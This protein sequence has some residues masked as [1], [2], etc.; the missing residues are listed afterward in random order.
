MAKLAAAWPR[1]L[2]VAELV[3]DDERRMALLR[4]YWADLLE[5]APAPSAFQVEVSERPAASP[6]A[7][8]Q[9]SRG[10]T[11]LITL[12]GT[13]VTLDDPV[14]RFFVSL[15][16]GSRTHDEIAEAMAGQVG[17]PL[18]AVRAALPDQLKALAR[19]PLLIS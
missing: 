10:E 2:P 8:L 6:L 16:D 18:D 11:R 5:L 9:I 15:L 1:S 4:M 13:V 19:M 14:S 17:E 3:D 12:R 7:R